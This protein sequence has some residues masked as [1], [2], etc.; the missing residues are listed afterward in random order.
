MDSELLLIAVTTINGYVFAKYRYCLLV[1]ENPFLEIHPFT[2]GGQPIPA[3]L[4]YPPPMM[5]GGQPIPAGLS[6]P[7]PRFLSS[8]WAMG[9]ELLLITFQLLMGMFHKIKI[10]PAGIQKPIS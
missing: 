4:S 2:G 1:Y 5:G 8:E 7:P 9:S 10:L 6:C 3:G